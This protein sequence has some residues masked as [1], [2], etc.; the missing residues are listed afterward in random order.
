MKMLYSSVCTGGYSESGLGGSWQAAGVVN[1]IK[2]SQRLGSDV[3]VTAVSFPQIKDTWKTPPV[4]F[5]CSG[6][7]WTEKA[8]H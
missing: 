8:R 6:I 4:Y 7:M 3:D 5:L 2:Y 1:S